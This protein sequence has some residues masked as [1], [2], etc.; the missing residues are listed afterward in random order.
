MSFESC[1]KIRREIVAYIDDQ[2]DPDLRAEVEVH[3]AGCQ[4]CRLRLDEL[5]KT[6]ARVDDLPLAIPA[7]D[8]LQRFE[9]RLEHERKGIIGEFLIWLLRPRMLLGASLAA[10]LLVVLFLVVRPGGAPVSDASELAIAGHMDLFSDY[11]AIENLD[12]LEDLEFI[13]SIDV[14]T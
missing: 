3:L 11:E 14:D 4:A 5:E 1:E 2:L 9:E 8:L 7:P 6:V 12:V 13:E 10:C